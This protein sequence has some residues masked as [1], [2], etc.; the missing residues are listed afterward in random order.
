[1][2]PIAFFK[3]GRHK[4]GTPNFSLA[5]LKEIAKSYDPKKHE[6]PLVLGHPAQNKPALGWVKKLFLDGEILKAE[7]RDVDPK[8]AEA[9]RK[10]RF[11]NISASFYRK[12][13]PANPSP[14]SWI[15]RHLGF[16]GSL[17]TAVKG[18][19]PISFAENDL[20]EDALF[21]K[22]ALGAEGEMDFVGDDDD[23]GDLAAMRKEMNQLN[24]K[25]DELE[26]NAMSEKN[27]KP[28]AGD[29]ETNFSEQEAELQK[30]IADVEKREAALEKKELAAQR[31]E[32]ESFAEELASEGKILPR[33]KDGL[34]EFLAGLSAEHTVNFAAEGGEEEEQSALKFA[35]D[36]LKSLPKQIEYG[37]LAKDDGDRPANVINFNAPPGMQVDAKALKLH[38]DATKLAADQKIP[39]NEAVLKINR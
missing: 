7:V 26:K 33:H 36:L 22:F 29:G 13:S 15:L 24:K 27:T 4:P 38:Q 8:F 37:E 30:K 14:G 1:M 5:D 16:F 3:P 35:E 18:L 2:E 11:P 10:R 25:I 31:K 17:A 21:F 12:D 23:G 6:A 28:A 39:Y 32:H 9:V 20:D 19:Q 34:I